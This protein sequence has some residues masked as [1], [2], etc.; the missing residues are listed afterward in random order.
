MRA[1]LTLAML[2]AASLAA[3]LVNAVDYPPDNFSSGECGNGILDADEECDHGV[4]NSDS[5]ACLQ[6]CRLATC[7]DKHIYPMFEQ[8]DDGNRLT[9]TCSYGDLT[10]TVC[11]TNCLAASG[12]T[13]FCGDGII[14]PQEACDDRNPSCGTCG[15][16]CQD[17]TCQPAFGIIHTCDGW[18]LSRLSTESFTLNDGYHD[19]VTFEFRVVD[20][21]SS[22]SQ[23]STITLNGPNIVISIADTADRYA[24]ATAISN[25]ING[26]NTPLSPFY[27][28]AVPQSS[29]GVASVHL[30]HSMAT[31]LGYIPISENV[32]TP[33]FRAYG[34]YGGADL[35]CELGERC[36]SDFD[37]E[38]FYLCLGGICVDDSLY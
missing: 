31:S 27:I 9:E 21:L 3:C 24:V 38:G 26:I 14:D 12:V 32:G 35:G 2:F 37:C 19:A 34:M 28:S 5:S 15:S 25:S 13:S 4:Q 20:S 23:T 8:C 30:T 29:D 7:G 36:S 16:T 6:N 17:Y 11:N 22:W 33:A 10:C 1:T 18:N